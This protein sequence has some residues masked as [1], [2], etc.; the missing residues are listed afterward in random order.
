MERCNKAKK[1]LDR[2]DLENNI[3]QVAK[4]ANLFPKKIESLKEKHGKSKKTNKSN[5]TS[6][7]IMHLRSHT[8]KIKS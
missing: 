4:A 3:N 7:S 8:Y 5:S 1:D 2:N 6:S